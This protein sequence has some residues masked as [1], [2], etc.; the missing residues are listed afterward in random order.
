MTPPPRPE[1]EFPWWLIAL[2]AI[3]GWMFFQV[4]SDAVYARILAT[5]SKG[6]GI[7]VLVTLVAFLG[8]AVLGLG[9]AVALMSRRMLLR[10]AARLYIEVVRGVPIIVLLLYVAFALTPALVAGWNALAGPLGLGAVGTRDFPLLSRAVLALVLAYSAFIAEVFRAGLQAVDIGQIEAAE[11][12]GLSRWLRFR[13]IVFP[14]AFRMI[15][16]PL[17]NDFVAMVKDSSLVSVLGVADITQLGKVTA[18]GNF[19]YFETYNVVAL[20]YLAMTVTLSLA[21]RRLEARLRSRGARD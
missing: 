13:H 4:L 5:L 2:A 21:L 6:I 3:G 11:A 7:T 17:G 1:T 18:A 9:L 12:L 15:L 14:Q 8:A 20:I 10:Q 16:P 19:R